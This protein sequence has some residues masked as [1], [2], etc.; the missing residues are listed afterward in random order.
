VAVVVL[1]VAGGVVAI[2]VAGRGGEPDV[3]GTHSTPAPSFAGIAAW[4]NSPPL[5]VEQLHGTV[6]LVDFWTYSCI[7]CLRTIPG[8]RALYQ[9]YAP[10]GFQIVGVHTPEF[11][12]E[13]VQSNVRAAVKRLDVT[14]PVAMDN[15]MSTWNAYGNHYWPH[16]YLIDRGGVIRYD[17]I[18]EGDEAQIESHIRTLLSQGSSQPLP[19][20]VSLPEPSFAPNMTPEIYAGYERGQ[21]TGTIANPQ[22]Y[23]PDHPV[24]Y[25]APSAATVANAPTTGSFFLEGT[26][27][28]HAET[29]E[30]RTAGRLL[31]PFFAR[32]VYIVAAAARPVTVRVLLDGATVATP[33][34]DVRGGLVTIGSSRLYALVALPQDGT[35][36][37][38]LEVPPGLQIYT[39]TF[40]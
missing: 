13:S 12:F 31:L 5:T 32:N 10:D 25:R 18:G 27:L 21:Q 36:V 23:S 22:G 9:R 14:W 3:G 34:Q 8:L 17:H 20:P 38:T 35:H 33:G 30:S 37:L 29:L 28:A 6:V 4:I 16:I 24:A 2:R 39:F 40:G 1:L 15:D 7:N 26:W 19:A 11:S